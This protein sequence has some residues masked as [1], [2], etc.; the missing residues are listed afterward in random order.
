MGQPVKRSVSNWAAREA[1]VWKETIAFR[2]SARE[3]YGEPDKYQASVR[4]TLPWR[5]PRPAL[6]RLALIERLS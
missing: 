6:R 1:R 5:C 2:S 3:R 4:R